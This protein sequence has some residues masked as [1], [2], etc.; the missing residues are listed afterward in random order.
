LIGADYLWVFAPM[1]GR[2]IIRTMTPTLIYSV[3]AA[4]VGIVIQ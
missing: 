1:R 3:I 2:I 4:I